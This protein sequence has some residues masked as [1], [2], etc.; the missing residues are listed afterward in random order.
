MRDRIA[1]DRSSRIYA[2][3]CLL[4]SR[5]QLLQTLDPVIFANFTKLRRDQHRLR[6]SNVV[7]KIG[8]VQHA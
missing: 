3:G 5:D 4:E 6:R 2:E 8:G 1:R 7:W